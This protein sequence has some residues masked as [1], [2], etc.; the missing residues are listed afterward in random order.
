[1]VIHYMFMEN[2]NI[3]NT[4]KL[5]TL[6]LLETEPKHGYQIIDDLEQMTGKRPTTSHIYPFLQ[7][8][9][10][11]EYVDTRK[12]GRKKV[13]ELTEDGE[14]FVDDQISSFSKILD[15]A[16]QDKI[17]ECAHCNC[18]IYGEGHKENQKT[19]CCKH[20]ANADLE[21]IN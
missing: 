9:A 13:Y 8:L 19:Y 5:Y 7:E 3:S 1:M 12:D 6:L 14:N 20:C 10:E 15:A 4:T 17:T 16:L 21:N 11:R 2:L 18:K